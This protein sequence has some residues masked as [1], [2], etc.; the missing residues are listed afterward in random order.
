MW[1]YNYLSDKDF[2]S[3]LDAH[4]EREIYAKIVALT[5]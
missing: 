2:L 3:Q 5:F 4:R 1:Q